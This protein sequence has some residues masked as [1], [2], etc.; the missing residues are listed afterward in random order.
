VR[1]RTI[2]LSGLL[3][4]S[5]LGN[6]ILLRRS[7]ETPALP[8]PSRDSNEAR[9][10]RAS[11]DHANA[12]LA[13]TKADLALLAAKPQ[14]SIASLPTVVEPP[15]RVKQFKQRL[16]SLKS[17]WNNR[18]NRDPADQVRESE[19]RTE[20]HRLEIDRQQ[21]P[22]VYG[23]CMAA[24]LE[25]ILREITPPMEPNQQAALQKTLAEFTGR[26]EKVSDET[27]PE[28]VA[29]ELRLESDLWGRLKEILTGDQFMDASTHPLS[30]YLV[31]ESMGGLT[32]ASTKTAAHLASIWAASL[33]A[34]AQQQDSF[35]GQAK[36]YVETLQRLEQEVAPDGE[37]W[38][39]LYERKGFDLRAKAM[40]LQADALKGLTPYLTPEQVQK[41]RTVSVE[42]YILS[43]PEPDPKK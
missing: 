19:L 15:D 37:V 22:A 11:L 32:Q 2:V 38:D 16:G 23:K 25:N 35:Q 12:E 21:N 4:A 40:Q 9:N 18:V 7:G 13:S 31:T 17:G 30:H 3:G 14:A 5:L 8:P 33:G 10:L 29:S 6:L 39:I 43:F 36:F 26:F 1:L 41:L 24:C 34:S 42:E 28:R 27:T 20:F